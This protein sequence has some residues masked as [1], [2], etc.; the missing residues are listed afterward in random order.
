MA[1]RALGHYIML[2]TTK[3]S[4]DFIKLGIDEKTISALDYLKFSIPP[5]FKKKLSLWH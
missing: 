5:L 3:H 4:N 1:L 2:Q